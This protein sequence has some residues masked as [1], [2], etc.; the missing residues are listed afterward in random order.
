MSQVKNFD[1]EIIT[2]GM[3]A[4]HSVGFKNGGLVTLQQEYL[5][6]RRKAMDGYITKSEESRL[7]RLG[8]QIDVRKR[9]LFV[10]SHISISYRI[11]FSL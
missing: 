11:H 9:Y 1:Y 6:L 8:L 3:P 10:T 5:R 4:A 7:E 2:C